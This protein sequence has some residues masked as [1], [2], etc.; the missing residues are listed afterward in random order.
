MYVTIVNHEV[1][2]TNHVAKKNNDHTPYLFN[3]T[4]TNTCSI[5]ASLNI[6][7]NHDQSHNQNQNQSHC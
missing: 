4:D 1:N 3:L 5:G 6:N 2:F 7:Q